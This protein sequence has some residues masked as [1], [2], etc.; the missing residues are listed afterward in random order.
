M[1]AATPRMTRTNASLFFIG[2]VS[3][4]EHII[5]ADE[6]ERSNRDCTGPPEHLG[7]RRAPFWLLVILF[8]G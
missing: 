3:V 8:V 1:V 4:S 6:G 7:K 5:I 2:P